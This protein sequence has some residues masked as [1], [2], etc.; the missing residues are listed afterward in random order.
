V[1]QVFATGGG[2]TNPSGVDGALATGLQHQAATPTATVGGIAAGVQYVGASP[3]LVNG[4]MQVNIQI[5]QVA[6]GAQPLVITMRGAS[7]Q[8]SITVAVE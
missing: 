5:P 4:V 6:S 3:G 7:S 8:S 1:V 2:V